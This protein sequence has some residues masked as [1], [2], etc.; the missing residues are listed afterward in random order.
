MWLRES[1]YTYRVKSLQCDCFWV[2]NTPISNHLPF[3]I[4]KPNQFN[5]SPG[6]TLMK[7][8]FGLSAESYEDRIDIT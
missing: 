5:G 1:H 6:G 8:D 4:S 3:S 7:W 2:S